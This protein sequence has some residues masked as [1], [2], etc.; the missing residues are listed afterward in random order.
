MDDRVANLTS[1]IYS[2]LPVINA[3]TMT[4]SRLSHVASLS[5]LSVAISFPRPWWI[6]KLHIICM[7]DFIAK[8]LLSLDGSVRV[9]VGYM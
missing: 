1:S 2:Y 7:V 9:V 3:I 5:C 4:T 8:L 6:T